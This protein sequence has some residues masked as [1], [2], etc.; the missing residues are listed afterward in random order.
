MLTELT[1]QYFKKPLIVTHQHDPLKCFNSSFCVAQVATPHTCKAHKMYGIAIGAAQVN[2]NGFYG[3]FFFRAYHFAA[4]LSS[5]A[6]L[7]SRLVCIGMDL[8]LL[9][10]N[11]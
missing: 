6:Y 4:L 5:F 8:R 11:Q 1:I 3:S 10:P 7:S 2:L 9:T